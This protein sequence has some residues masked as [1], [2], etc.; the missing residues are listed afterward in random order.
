M[1][2]VTPATIAE[3]FGS[4]IAESL[5]LTGI[6][7][8]EDARYLGAVGLMKRQ[9]V[10]RGI[11]GFPWNGIL[12]DDSRFLVRPMVKSSEGRDGVALIF[13]QFDSSKYQASPEELFAGWVPSE[14]AAQLDAWV[15]D[16]NQQLAA[17]LPLKRR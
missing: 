4:G 14:Q 10:F 13:R 12:S 17:L 15:A 5:R 1:G 6:V 8:D 3:I 16:M 11:L 7:E 9:P 2:L